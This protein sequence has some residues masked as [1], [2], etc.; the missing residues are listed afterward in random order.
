MGVRWQLEILAHRGVSGIHLSRAISDICDIRQIRVFLVLR[1]ISPLATSRPAVRPWMVRS[2]SARRKNL[3]LMGDKR[4]ELRPCLFSIVLRTSIH[5]A[6]AR[7]RWGATSICGLRAAR[8]E[9]ELAALFVSQS[10]PQTSAFRRE[11]EALAREPR[12]GAPFGGRGTCGWLTGANQVHPSPGPPDGAICGGAP[13]SATPRPTSRV[14]VDAGSSTVVIAL[15]K[16]SFSHLS[17]KG[18]NARPITRG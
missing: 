15:S 12:E 1:Y 6:I 4:T 14:G 3:V 10:I 2:S 11:L 18:L 17:P 16:G 13:L 9:R 8:V 7:L 5:T